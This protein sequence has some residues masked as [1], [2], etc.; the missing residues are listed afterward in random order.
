MKD[1]NKIFDAIH[2]VY[3]SH[4]GGGIWLDDS[5]KLLIKNQL[6]QLILSNKKEYLSNVS[7]VAWVFDCWDMSG[8]LTTKKIQATCEEHAIL[9]FEKKHKG[10]Y[11]YDR[12]Y[13]I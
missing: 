12:P 10:E 6:R 1:I 3:E 9:K 4:D 5:E 7:M 8:R 2:G 13:L 11:G